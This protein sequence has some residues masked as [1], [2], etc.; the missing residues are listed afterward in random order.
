MSIFSHLDGEYRRFVDFFGKKGQKGN[1][2]EYD[3][4]LLRLTQENNRMTYEA[5]AEVANLSQ[6]AVRRRMKRFRDEGII[7]G[8][9]SLLHNNS[10]G[11]L[12]ICRLHCRELTQKAYRS[13]IEMVDEAPEAL[14][15]YNVSG[16]FDFVIVAQMRDM[17]HYTHWLENQMM[18]NQYIVHCETQFVYRQTKFKTAIPV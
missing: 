14:Q 16:E 11:F 8:D 9:V 1:M 12:V 6:S 5:M 4:K 10:L 15:C 2:D 18:A 7:I 3:R 13:I 17:E